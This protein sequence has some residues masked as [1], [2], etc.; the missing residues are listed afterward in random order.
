MGGKQLSFKDYELATSKK[1]TKRE[2]LLAEMEDSGAL[3]PTD[4]TRDIF[5]Y[6]KLIRAAAKAF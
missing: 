4:L 6:C 3:T 1:R 2:K 5:C